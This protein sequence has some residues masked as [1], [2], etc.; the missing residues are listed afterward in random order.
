MFVRTSP[1]TIAPTSI[2]I[3]PVVRTHLCLPY[4]AES[5]AFDFL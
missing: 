5:P 2:T 4:F 3:D 1:Y